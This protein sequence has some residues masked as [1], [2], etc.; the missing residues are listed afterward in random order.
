MTV[1]PRPPDAKQPSHSSPPGLTGLTDDEAARRLAAGEGNATALPTSRSYREI[2]RQ[3]VFNFIN[4][5]IFGLGL[6][7]ATLGRPLDALVSVGVILANSAV[8]VVQ[9][10]R[11]KW[12][13][14]RIALLTRPTATVLRS[15]RQLPI[16]PGTV[17]RGDVLWVGPGEQIVA[18]GQLVGDT[19]VEVDESLL[20]GESRPV[21]KRAGDAVSSGSF[22]VAGEGWYV[23]TTVGTK[24]AA[25]QLAAEARAYRHASTPL[26][27]EINLIIR[28]VLLVA[29]LLEF[30]TVV[31]AAIDRLPVVETVSMSVVILGLVP[32]GLVLAIAV[33]YGAAAVRMSGQGILVEQSN[34]I[35][36]LSHVDLLCLDKTGTLT[37]GRLR[38]QALQ[39]YGIEPAELQHQLGTFA[40]SVAAPNRTIAAIAGAYPGRPARVLSEVPFSSARRWS[41]VA[42]DV[43]ASSGYFVLGAA[44]TLAPSLAPDATRQEK[45]QEWTD[46]GLRVLLFARQSGRDAA[47]RDDAAPE[48]PP[49]LTPLGLIALADELRADAKSTL[50]A[51]ADA[52][53]RLKI[54]SGDDPKTVA[55]LARQAGFD[56]SVASIDGPTLAGLPSE[57]IADVAENTSIFGRIAPEQ[58]RDVL[59]G[60]QQR[61]HYVAM[62]GD[63]VNDVLALKQANLGIAL[64]SGTAAARGVADLVLLN[65]S[66]G[67]LPR[68]VQEGQR[69]RNGMI[70]ILKLFLTRVFSIALLLVGTGIVG[71]FPLGPRHNALL[72]LLTVGIPSVALAAWARPGA[73]PRASVLRQF[74]HFVFPAALT[75]SLVELSVDVV[76]F[77][78]THQ[79][80]APTLG[81]RAAEIQ[82]IAVA[83][84]AVTTVGVAC[85]LLLL[86]FVA[87]PT[88]FWVGGDDLSGDWRPSYLALG[89]FVALGCICAIPVLRAF[90]ALVPLGSDTY[91]LLAV[92]V[93]VWALA[94]RWI[95]R[96]RLVER[97]LELDDAPR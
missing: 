53:V 64:G 37:T 81:D 95:W 63:G 42:L 35:E 51:F 8:G 58:K 9:E 20:T 25:Y 66:F 14:D 92:L 71:E 27:R 28:I 43:G 82:A 72:T 48:L 60:L 69:V 94:L 87:P 88:A 61:G 23:A 46:Q 74:F 1:A 29:V 31:D 45:I 19:P 40:A 50:A 44:D 7:L 2:V 54:I 26:Q 24:S 13:L 73:A 3:N 49:R 22:G 47:T 11:A 39:P 65:D 75:I 34:G 79:A 96:A 62:T 52:G 97:Y 84:T 15:G 68:A 85:G 18:D 83:Q 56:P 70:D 38:V 76:A 33:A 77:L 80:L 93:V 90:F 59:R 10:V 16:D 30:I 5:V 12:T 57:S 36:S 78:Q 41:A 32:N 89:L 55:A 21:T 91:A 17:V 4:V 86:V 67:S 6:A